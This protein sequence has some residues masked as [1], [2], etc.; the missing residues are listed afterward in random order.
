MEKTLELI[1]AELNREIYK[2]GH[3]VTEV[4]GKTYTSFR[5]AARCYLS[6]RAHTQFKN[7]P[8]NLWPYD[9]EDWEPGDELQSLVKAGA[10][11]AAE[12]ERVKAEKVSNA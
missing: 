4:A 6:S 9:K 8:P 2:S 11:I 12:I 3:H 5:A 10:F 7:S 1:E